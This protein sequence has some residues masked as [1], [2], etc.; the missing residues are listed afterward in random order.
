MY[1]HRTPIRLIARPKLSG[2]GEHVGVELP[3]G[4]VVHRTTSGNELVPFAQFAQGRPVRAV[5]DVPPSEEWRV[6][7]RIQAS[8]RA[9]ADYRLLDNNCE[10]YATGLIGEK[11]NSPQVAVLATIAVFCLVAKA[12]TS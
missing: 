12:V 1:M 9:P 7:G 6:Y 8:L 4:H 5:K 2:I 11:P 10:H 3:S